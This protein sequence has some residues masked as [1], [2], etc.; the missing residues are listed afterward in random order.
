MDRVKAIYTKMYR[1][2]LRMRKKYLLIK[3]T[4]IFLKRMGF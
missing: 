2:R 3:A 4:Y 1:R